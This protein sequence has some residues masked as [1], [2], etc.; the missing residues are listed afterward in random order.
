MPQ[1]FLVSGPVFPGCFQPES[2]ES[3]GGRCVVG[4]ARMRRQEHR[5]VRTE[6]PSL[7]LRSL[8]LLPHGRARSSTWACPRRPLS[9][10]AGR[11]QCTRWRPWRW[12]GAHPG[13]PHDLPT[14]P[15]PPSYPPTYAP[16]AW[17]HGIPSPAAFRPAGPLLSLLRLR[18]IAAATATPSL[19]SLFTRTVEAEVVPACRELGIAILAYSPLGRGMLTGAAGTRGSPGADAGQAR[20]GDR[21]AARALLLLRCCWKRHLRRGKEAQGGGTRL[22]L[23]LRSQCILVPDLSSARLPPRVSAQAL[24]A[25]PR[26][27][28]KG[29]SAPRPRGC[30]GRTWTKTSRSAATTT[31]SRKC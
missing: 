21:G 24:S 15:H 31:R 9:T 4:G 17:L 14:S 10:S 2:F 18:R 12:N 13:W 27:S 23:L 1:T 20:V 6:R 28:P 19:R 7:L 5:F 16:S 8:L 26:T 3:Q 11:T 22:L 30:R 29:T 25:R